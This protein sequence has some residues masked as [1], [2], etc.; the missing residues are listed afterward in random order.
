MKLIYPEQITFTARITEPELRER[1]AKEV[2][3]GIGAIDGE[4][5][6]APGVKYHVNRN[7]GGH[8]GYTI[9]VQGPMPARMR[10]EPPK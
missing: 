3:D 7:S 6:A 9:T 4:G 5:N 8:G 1:L 2:L 10:I